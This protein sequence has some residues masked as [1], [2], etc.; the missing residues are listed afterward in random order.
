[1]N[2][3]EYRVEGQ[4]LLKG[5]FR[6]ALRP[7]KL[8]SPLV[9]TVAGHLAIYLATYLA[10][11][12]VF[13]S[14]L[15]FTVIA[16]L[17]VFQVICDHLDGE[18]ARAT[19]SDSAMGEF[20]D[21]F[22][23]LL[24]QCAFALIFI[25]LFN[26]EHSLV[27]IVSAISVGA[28]NTAKYYDQYKRNLLVKARLGFAEVKVLGAL[29]LL[30]C[31]FPKAYAFINLPDGSSFSVI[32]VLVM[33]ISFMNLIQIIRA[34]LRIP[35]ISYGMWLFQGF[36]VIIAVLA[37][38]TYD[39][40]TAMLIVFG[41]SILYVGRLLSAQLTDGVEKSPDFFLLL[42]IVIQYFTSFFD[43]SNTRLIILIYLVVNVLLVVLKTYRVLKMHKQAT[44]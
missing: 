14:T 30:L 40:L 6:K 19:H 10:Y 22:F 5:F 36:H 31:I 33:A 26:V 37:F 18:M 1:M 34:L 24:N 21:H 43:S 32:E 29:I 3:Y 25:F 13:A 12:Q 9:L 39:G 42:F 4:S 23:E 7:P 20:T 15:N 17:I 38:L 11:A 8:S 41:Y 28:V 35:H 2:S 44:Q 16:V 27:Y